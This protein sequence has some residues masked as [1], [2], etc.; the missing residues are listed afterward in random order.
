MVAALTAIHERRKTALRDGGEPSTRERNP[1]DGT[2]TFSAAQH[3]KT[4]LP[5]GDVQLLTGGESASVCSPPAAAMSS[6]A[7]A[8]ALLPAVVGDSSVAAARADR[9]APTGLLPFQKAEDRRSTDRERA[10]I[11]LPFQVFVTP[12]PVRARH[13]ATM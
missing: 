2:L 9:I 8:C 7:T 11:A 12:G 3:T 1:P 10:S 13:L 5:D 4:Y 6:L